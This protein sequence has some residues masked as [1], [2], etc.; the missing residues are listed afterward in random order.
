MFCCFEVKK[1]FYDPDMNTEEMEENEQKCL[2]FMQNKDYESFKYVFNEYQNY[3]E[4]N[5]T[6]YTSHVKA[7]YL[8]I[9]FSEEWLEYSYYLQKLDYTDISDRYIQFVLNIEIILGEK[10]IDMLK[11][12]RGKIKEFD[13]CLEKIISHN[14][15]E[16][17]KKYRMDQVTVQ[18]IR[19]ENPM[20]TISKC[21]E[22]SRKFNKV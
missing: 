1:S 5:R 21:L 16:Q 20:E 11:K 7:C 10:N 3:Y 8:M 2:T 22:F 9:L 6:K 13:D 14:K 19:D 17:N 4:F 18:E 12:E 15:D